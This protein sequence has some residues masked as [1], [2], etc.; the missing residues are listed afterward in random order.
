[1]NNQQLTD[2]CKGLGIKPFFSETNMEIESLQYFSE[3]YNLQLF[4]LSFTARTM[5]N[6]KLFIQTTSN[7][8]KWLL[9]IMKILKYF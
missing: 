6:M 5:Q 3:H 8:T 1:M 7:D 9:K 2:T 4:M